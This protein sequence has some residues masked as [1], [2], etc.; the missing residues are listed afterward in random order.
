MQGNNAQN[1][2][3]A[4][5]AD[6]ETGQ[7]HGDDGISAAPG[8]SA[9][10]FDADIG[11]IGRCDHMDDG[12]ADVH[13]AGIVGEQAQE[14]AASSHDDD[15]QQH[16]GEGGHSHTDA[17]TFFDAV[18]LARA[19]ILSGEGGDGNAVSAHD[20][21]E[22][23]VH[24]AVGCPGGDGIR[25]EG[26]DAGLND[27]VGNGVHGRLQARRQ[28]DPDDG[29]QDAGGEADFPRIQLVHVVGFHQR[30]EN[31]AGAGKLRKGGGD[32]DACHAH[33][34]NYHKE[35]IQH[36]VGQGGGNQ[37]IQRTF[38]VPDGAQNT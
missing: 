4:Q 31:H 12:H 16:A 18:I 6:A 34:Q 36:D 35:Q 33:F 10:N 26:V 29:G 11:D 1:P 24:L 37:V 25:P 5:D 13:Y 30:I 23:A 21:P 20:H 8:G 27:Q 28:S 32:G 2:D 22:H 17:H 3:H 15:T 14:N 9:Q 38:G 19:E 7:K